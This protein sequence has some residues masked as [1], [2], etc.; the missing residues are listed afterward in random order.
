[1]ATTI[2]QKPNILSA[3]NTPLIYILT[4]DTAS[5]YNAPK[6]KYVIKVEI[7]S[8]LIATIKIHKNQQN[9]GIFDISHIVKNYV[10]TQ[11]V[12]QNDTDY[13]IHTV[14]IQQTGKPFSQN[15]NQCAKVTVKAYIEKATSTTTSPELSSLQQTSD[16]YLVPATTPYTKTEDHIGGLDINGSNQPLLYTMNG[17]GN[18]KY[19]FFT[20]APAVQFVRGSSTSAD[21]LDQL[22]ICFKQKGSSMINQGASLDY[23]FIEYYNSAGS[24]IGSAIDFHNT[25]SNG[26]SLESE[27][28]TVEESILYFGC[29]TKNLETQSLKTSARPSNI[30]DWSYY[31]IYGSTSNST[32]DRCTKKYYFYR[33][34]SGATVDDRH[35]SCTRYDNVRLCWVNRLGAWD[36]MNFRG[37]STESISIKNSDMES[38]VGNWDSATGN[39]FNYNNWDKGKSTLFKTATRKLTIN[40]DWLNEDE[41]VWLEEL[42]TSDNV[43]ILDDNPSIIYPVIVTNKAYTKKTSVNDKIKIQ[44]TIDLE[45]SNKV[46]TNS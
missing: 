42:F 8:N 15:S 43:Q 25:N 14:G 11:L 20:N 31:A 41:A 16:S 45:Y 4:E 34:G 30:A 35:Q 39:T 38:V 18:E 29:G 17:T 23:I 10:E 5:N 46:R 24:I 44:Y 32:S 12:N 2:T 26:G 3:V 28:N 13:S 22:T 19:G 27:T 1:M 21:N 40:T 33:Y 7:N 9:V 37:K 6:F 36:Y